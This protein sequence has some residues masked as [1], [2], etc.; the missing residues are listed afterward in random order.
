MFRTE[1]Q[2]VIDMELK[3]Y[4]IQ[5]VFCHKNSNRERDSGICSEGSRKEKAFFNDEKHQIIHAKIKVFVVAI[6]FFLFFNIAFQSMTHIIITNAPSHRFT[7]RQF[8]D[9]SNIFISIFPMLK[10]FQKLKFL[11]ITIQQ[12]GEALDT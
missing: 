8:G 4:T 12:T 9:N 6:V 1:I 11:L 2:R 5:K 7:N 3:N 10:A